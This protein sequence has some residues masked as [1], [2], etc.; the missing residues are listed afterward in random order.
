MVAGDS[1]I[2]LFLR[3]QLLAQLLPKIPLLVS[4]PWLPMWLHLVTGS[5]RTLA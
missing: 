5:G 1:I 3:L 2:D 4:P